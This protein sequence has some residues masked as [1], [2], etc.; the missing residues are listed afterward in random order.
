[1]RT[2][3][4]VSANYVIGTLFAIATAAI[5]VPFVKTL[6]VTLVSALAV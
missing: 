6:W 3:M 1:M 5:I 4:S 2:L